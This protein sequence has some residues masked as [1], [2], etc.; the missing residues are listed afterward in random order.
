MA[1]LLYIFS[2]YSVLG[3]VLEITFFFIKTG[4][5]H[6]RG[7]LGGPYCPLYGFSIAACTAICKNILNN[8]FYMFLI[9]MIVCTA[10]ELITGIILDKFLDRKMWDYNNER[11]NFGGYICFR[12]SLI[13]GALGTVSVKYLNPVLTYNADS[14]SVIVK[15][16]FT[17]AVIFAM[18]VNLIFYKIP[19]AKH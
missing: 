8:L 3:W 4:K 12:F 7:I 13:W 9:C 5:Y 11:L 2:L 19:F 18:T 16:V 6:K 14:T 1:E 10:F 17:L 15:S